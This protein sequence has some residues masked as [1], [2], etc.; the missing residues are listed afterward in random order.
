M[1]DN[2]TPD[3]CSNCEEALCPGEGHCFKSHAAISAH[4]ADY[5][6]THANEH[7]TR[8]K[9]VKVTGCRSADATPCP[10]L[11]FHE[12][13]CGL[14]EKRPRREVPLRKTGRPKWCPLLTDDK[15]NAGVRIVAIKELRDD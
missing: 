12:N 14:D 6:A 1:S 8:A 5:F 3:V 13:L 11:W 2:S 10:A 4:H 9:L 15:P 7:C